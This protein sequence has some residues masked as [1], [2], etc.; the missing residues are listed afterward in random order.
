MV[1]IKDNMIRITRG[2]SCS[3]N[4]TIYES[5]GEIPYIPTEND[6]IYLTVKPDLNNDYYVIKKEFI[7]GE[8][9]TLLKSDTIDLNFGRYFYDVRL[10]N[11]NNFDT[12]IDQGKFYI[13]GGTANARS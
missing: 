4:L 11:H 13:E 7:N 9:V 6:T 12:I 1:T 8:T 5:D 10:E 2:D 3:I